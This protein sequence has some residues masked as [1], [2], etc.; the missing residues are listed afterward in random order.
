VLRG[1]LVAVQKARE[2]GNPA[3][4]V[5]GLREIARLMGFYPDSRVKVDVAVSADDHTDRMNR[6]SDAELMKIIESGGRCSSSSPP[7]AI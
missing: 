3:A 5:S 4:M 7:A 6:L 2:M 1:L